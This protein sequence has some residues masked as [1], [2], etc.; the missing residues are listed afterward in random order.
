MAKAPEKKDTKKVKKP[1]PLKRDNQALKANERNR[2]FKASVKTAIRKLETSLEGANAAE[3][4]SSLDQVFSMMDKGAKRGIFKT[5]KASR[6]KSR[7][8]TRVAK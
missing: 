8:A 2:A 1:T 3:K 6:I 4:Q 7:L 5:N